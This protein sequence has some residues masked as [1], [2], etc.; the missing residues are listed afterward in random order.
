MR[1]VRRFMAFTNE[2]PWGCV[3]TA[4]TPTSSMKVAE[5]QAYSYP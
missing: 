4:A 2:Y 1:L 3:A 5:V